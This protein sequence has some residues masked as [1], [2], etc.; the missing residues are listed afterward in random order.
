MSTL[1]SSEETVGIQKSDG[2]V[3][4]AADMVVTAMGKKTHVLWVFS[5][6]EVQYRRMPGR[7]AARIHSSF[8]ILHGYSRPGNWRR[9]NENEQDC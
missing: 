3:S 4:P 7:P 9:H 5:A 6:V 1:N 8:S 2:V